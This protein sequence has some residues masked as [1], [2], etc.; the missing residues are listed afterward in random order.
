VTPHV[1]LKAAGG[2]RRTYEDVD[3]SATPLGPIE[4]WSPALRNATDLALHTQFPVMLMWG[5]ELVMVYNEAYV[6]LIADKH[7]SALG[8]PAREVF[9]EAWDTIGPLAQAVLA[10]EGATWV[11]DEPVPLMRRGRLEE[12]Y[13][14]FS[15]S[16]V[17][18]PGGVIEGVMDIAIETTRQV[19]DRRRLRTLGRLREILAGLD[20][21]HAILERGIAT[22]RADAADF[23]SVALRPAHA[24]GTMRSP[25]RTA[26][27]R[28]WSATSRATTGA[29]RRRWRRSATCCA[30]S[31]TRRPAR[32]R[33]ASPGST[34]RW[35]ASSSARSPP[36]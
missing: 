17:R 26:G 3:W 13:F 16:P 15:Y 20:S 1:L 35:P 12:A 2:L 14:T 10:G 24:I 25:A 4:R 23:P 6:E 18:G 11:E 32:R 31:R 27:S 21:A 5:P 8:S 30:A 7:P 33:A 29:P 9:P 22:L 28:S 19:I 36:P 34:A